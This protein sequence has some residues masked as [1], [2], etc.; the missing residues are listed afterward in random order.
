V[1]AAIPGYPVFGAQ[2]LRYTLATLVLAAACWRQRRRDPQ[3]R[4]RPRRRL[5]RRDAVL[6][7]V[8]ATVGVSGF[9]YC[10]A[11]AVRRTGAA[12]VGMVIATVPVVLAIAGP[13]AAGRP[14]TSPGACSSP[15]A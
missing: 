11:E 5:T 8:Q 14:P 15:R 4:E 13:L 10:A 1:N 12:T 7:V 3:R 2:A 6:L 9:N